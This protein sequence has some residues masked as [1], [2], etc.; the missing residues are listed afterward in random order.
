MIPRCWRKC[1]LGRHHGMLCA[2][3]DFKVCH[4]HRALG[5]LAGGQ[6]W[7][8]QFGWHGVLLVDLGGLCSIHHEVAIRRHMPHA[9]VLQL[10][11]TGF[12]NPLCLACTPELRLN[13]FDELVCRPRRFRQVKEV[14]ISEITRLLRGDQHCLVIWLEKQE[15]NTFRFVRLR[16]I[17]LQRGFPISFGLHGHEPILRRSGSKS[18]FGLLPVR[19]MWNAIACHI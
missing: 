2:W 11:A 14:T 8:W 1:V 16:I 12:E 9:E 7:F 19:P 18:Q 5:V 13:W 15:P 3:P 6:N 17:F 10:A 4:T